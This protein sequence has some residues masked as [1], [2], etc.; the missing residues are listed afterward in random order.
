MTKT[1]MARA[2]AAETGLTRSQVS[3]VIRRVLD[4]IT[5]ALVSEGRVELRNFAVFEVRG[6]WPRVRARP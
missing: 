6:R 5:E 1:D 3:E 2:I 4:G